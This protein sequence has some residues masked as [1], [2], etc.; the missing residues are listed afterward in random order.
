[1]WQ[2]RKSHR[3]SFWNHNSSAVYEVDSFREMAP[4]RGICGAESE[5]DPLLSQFI[6]SVAA[7]MNTD[8]ANVNNTREVTSRPSEKRYKYMRL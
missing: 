5:P 8:S 1:M 7:P 4:K 3:S 6:C 2:R